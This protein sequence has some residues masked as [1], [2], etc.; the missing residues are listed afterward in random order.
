MAELPQ[1]CPKCGARLSPSLLGDVCPNCVLGAAFE[2]GG[3]N[4]P[5]SEVAEEIGPYRLLEKIGEGGL[6]VVYMAEQKE[7][8]RRRVAIK[9]IKPGMDS[10][11]VIARFEAERQAL[12]MMDHPNIARIFD[13]GTTE[14]GHPYFAMELVRGIRITDYCDRHNL[15]TRERLEMFMVVS[16][17]VQHAHQ[18]GVIH[19]DLKPSN[20]LVTVNDGVAVP[21]IIDFGIAKA[22][23]QPLTDKTIFTRFNQLLGTPAY[24]SPEQAEL[25]SLDVDTRTDIYSLGVLLYELLTGHTPF[26]AKE[27]FKAGLE[28]ML[29]TIRQ[30]EPARPSACLST[31][32]AADLTAIA[33]QRGTEPPGL[34]HAVRGDLDWIVMKCLEKDRSRRYETPSSLAADV[35]RH[36][37]QEPVMARPPSTGYRMQKFVRRNRL[38]VGAVASVVIILVVALITTGWLWRRALKAQHNERVQHQRAEEKAAAEAQAKEEA[39]LQSEIAVSERARAEDSLA[40]VQFQRAEELFALN[41]DPAA[42][43]TLA[44]VIRANPTNHVAAQRLLS[45]LSHNHFPSELRATLEEMGAEGPTLLLLKSNGTFHV[46]DY[47]S[48]AARGKP[49]RIT[50][51]YAKASFSVDSERVVAY[52]RD[53]AEIWD[54]ESGKSLFTPKT[55][56]HFTYD[57]LPGGAWVIGRPSFWHSNIVVLDVKRAKAV[58]V[59]VRNISSLTDVTRGATASKDGTYAAIWSDSAR[60]VTLFKADDNL[61]S[62]TVI[63]TP[64]IPKKVIISPDGRLIAV[65]ESVVHNQPYADVWIMDTASGEWISSGGATDQSVRVSTAEN[66]IF[67]DDGERYA[68]ACRD[69]TARIFQSKTSEQVTASLKHP[70]AV[71]WL[72]FSAD[73]KRLVT[74]CSD[75]A[76]RV[77]N[78][79]TGELV[80]APIKFKDAVLNPLFSPEGDR[81]AAYSRDRTASLVRLADG[82]LLGTLQHRAPMSGMVFS[83]DGSEIQ[84]RSGQGIVQL[85]DGYTG[86]PLSRPAL[87]PPSTGQPTFAGISVIATYP[88][89]K[90]KWTWRTR[91]RQ[92][93]N[94][95]SPPGGIAFAE[96]DDRG[97]VAMALTRSNT[98]HVWDIQTGKLRFPPITNQT[99]ARLSPDGKRL[100]TVSSYLKLRGVETGGEGQLRDSRSGVPIG[101]PLKQDRMHKAVFSLD[102]RRLATT[103]SRVLLERP[104]FTRSYSHLWN[105]ESGE[106]IRQLSDDTGVMQ[107]TFAKSGNKLVVASASESRLCDSTTGEF[108]SAFRGGVHVVLGP[109]GTRAL[110]EVT[111]QLWRFSEA[112]TNAES[113]NLLLDGMGRRLGNLRGSSF[114][115][116]GQKLIGIVSNSS[117]RIW[118]A[119]TG[120]ARGDYLKHG[121]RIL[122]AA[123]APDG[124]VAATTSEDGTARLWNPATGAPLCEPLPH[125]GEVI[126]GHFTPD[127]R[128]LFTISRDGRARGWEV[129]TGYPVSDTLSHDGEVKSLRIIPDGQCLVVVTDRSLYIWDISTEYVP[130]EAWLPELAEV[131]V[132]QRLNDHNVLEPVNFARF[133]E[134][135]RL[136]L[137]NTS[138]DYF[139]RWGRWFVSEPHTRTISLSQSITLNEYIDRSI[140]EGT[141]ESLRD[142]VRLS[143]TNV[144]ALRR[145]AKMAMADDPSQTPEAPWEADHP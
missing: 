70:A 4:A 81:L 33:R 74:V 38:A 56:Y 31:L 136:I 114:S 128:R 122:W 43:A 141:R 95:L 133:E 130:V 68:I 132:G 108:L 62:P 101:K 64:C 44:A 143:S 121:G 120:S 79:D 13:A 115:V 137:A 16:R 63:K 83:L 67:S 15:S 85:W 10:R 76:V 39:K 139:A 2:F 135:R 106:S 51:N 34:I 32:A 87:R 3:P 61:G 19:R 5:Q 9:L 8:I 145:A 134:L 94:R 131:V 102:G 103:M 75:N 65:L 104:A 89:P 40:R 1:H 53:K 123:F 37:E 91:T 118:D 127:S 140:R 11:E 27:L 24:M 88:E 7:P 60:I 138:T 125:G 46:I 48:K 45:A 6:G 119:N 23:E 22:T 82:K 109:D 113:V 86:E 92:V 42:V 18:K 54:I 52:S 25:T 35:T 17:A 58:M 142:V 124:R 69:R 49:L 28:H 14:S 36:V 78:A 117:A 66:L 29:R 20:I 73:R 105:G 99:E 50:D 112:G 84:T 47:K 57:A 126:F 77:W 96:I 80:G 97:Q 129:P 90:P 98:V 41:D 116:D 55:Y 72:Q 12:A 93:A 21:K 26:D 59:P 110:T 144:L 100:L 30:T 111:A 71:V 107:P